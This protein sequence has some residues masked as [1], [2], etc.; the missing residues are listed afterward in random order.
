M[1][2]IGLE[3]NGRT[4]DDVN[5]VGEPIRDDTFMMLLNPHHEPIRFFMPRAEGTAWEVLI[6]SA[7]PEQDGEADCGG[8]GGLRADSPLARCCCA[9]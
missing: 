1:R 9:R 6:D 7:K 5:G 8:G 3:L 2:C 4:L